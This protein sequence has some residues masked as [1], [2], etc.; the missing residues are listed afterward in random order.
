MK[1][2]FS[3]S[4]QNQHTHQFTGALQEAHVLG[5]V[6]RE[7]R[8]SGGA[9]AGALAGLPDHHARREQGKPHELHRQ[10]ARKM[11]SA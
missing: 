9:S 6:R 11:A 5:Q 2:F 4:T 7:L 8:H 3:L 1:L 10:R